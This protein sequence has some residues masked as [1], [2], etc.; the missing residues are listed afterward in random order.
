MLEPQTAPVTTEDHL[1][2]KL[3]AAGIGPKE[4]EI[5]FG[6]TKTLSG[7]IKTGSLEVATVSKVPIISFGEITME[8]EVMKM[9]LK[10]H[11]IKSVA[12]KM[13]SKVM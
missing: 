1:S 4:I 8:L 7:A 12:I 3:T 9:A 2:I 10:A 5:E 6:E 11:G 13:S